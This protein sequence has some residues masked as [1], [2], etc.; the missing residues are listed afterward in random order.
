MQITSPA[1][2]SRNAQVAS[3]MP[4]VDPSA[5]AGGSGIVVAQDLV[6]RFTAATAAS[7][8]VG[9]RAYL[10]F[11]GHDKITV[12]GQ[13]P[14]L[15]PRF[16]QATHQAVTAG[17]REASVAVKSSPNGALSAA[18][19]AI[20]PL[21]LNGVPGDVAGYVNDWYQPAIRALEIGFS[22][23][24]FIQ[25][26]KAAHPAA[27]QPKS[28]YPHTSMDGLNT[29]VEGI[30][31]LT[32]AAGMAGSVA[33]TLSPAL[34]HLGALGQTIAFTGDVAEF[35]INGMRYLLLRDKLTPAQ[36]DQNSEGN[37]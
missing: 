37:R 7:L 20:R 4:P 2:Q 25:G 21:I 19:L 5:P 12:E 30:H 22:A 26:W 1:L 8:P 29:T 36:V 6:D 27:G 9:N 31:V 10:E 16:L 35:A 18:A 32:S 34:G 24:A 13:K 11:A 23:R 15:M 17:A 3:Q 14:S 28:A 33:A